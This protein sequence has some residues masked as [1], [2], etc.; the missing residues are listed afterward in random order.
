MGK[1]K[2]IKD[3][4]YMNGWK[5]KPEIVKNCKHSKTIKELSMFDNEYICEICGFKYIVDSSG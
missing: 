1:K 2:E 5:I 3:L 4:G